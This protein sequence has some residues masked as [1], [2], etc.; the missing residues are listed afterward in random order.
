MKQSKLIPY[1][2]LSVFFHLC[3]LI[4]LYQ[5]HL[6]KEEKP[7][8]LVP[9]EVIVIRDMP[10]VSISSPIVLPQPKTL[11]SRPEPIPLLDY[12]QTDIMADPIP[13]E[14]PSTPLLNVA[15]SLHW[16]APSDKRQ[17]ANASNRM[18]TKITKRLP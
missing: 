5:Y 17:V 1:L 11:P 14:T 16:R 2:F 7:E 10:V 6:I 9:V 8:D 4:L 12:R 13:L 3:A 15:L 18:V